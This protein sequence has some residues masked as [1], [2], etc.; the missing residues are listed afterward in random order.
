MLSTNCSP[1]ANCGNRRRSLSLKVL[2]YEEV[3]GTM[4][5]VGSEEVDGS[6]GCVGLEEVDGSMGCVWRHRS[7]QSKEGLR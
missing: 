6:M 2:P 3:D 7:V 1:W 4:G 5:C